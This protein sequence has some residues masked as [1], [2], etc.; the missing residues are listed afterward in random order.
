MI[1]DYSKNYNDLN[2]AM[3][4]LGT[5][6]PAS[7]KSFNGLH[8][9]ST[10]KGALTK[11]T[12]ELI[13]LGIAITVRCD[14]CIAFHVHDSLQAGA[15]SEEIMETIGVAVMMG[16]GPSLV[17]G[18]EAMEALDQFVVLEKNEATVE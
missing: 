2:K 16:G 4:K 5:R 15:T 7:I 10:A 14:G 6:I 1:R 17:Y 8:T 11:K 13:A 3:K 9:A 18:C 12:K